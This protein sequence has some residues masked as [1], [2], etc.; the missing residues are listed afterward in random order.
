[1]DDIEKIFEEYIAEFNK[2]ILFDSEICPVCG[3]NV[4]SSISVNK[5]PFTEIIK[6]KNEKY[7]Q[8][9]CDE[10]K[11][12]NIELKVVSELDTSQIEQINYIHSILVTNKDFHTANEL[13]E[14]I[15]QQQISV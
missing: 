8:F 13:I 12:N 1:M 15:N 10:L 14:K 7:V 11:R 3:V 2:S 4:S 6:S 9:I 5:S